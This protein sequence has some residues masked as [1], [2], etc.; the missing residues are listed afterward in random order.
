MIHEYLIA[1]LVG[2]F[3]VLLVGGVF[4]G[5]H[6]FV[7]FELVE[8]VLLDRYPKTWHKVAWFMA[9]ILALDVLPWIVGLWLMPPWGS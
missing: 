4:V 2:L 9:T 1:Y 7:W 8:D 3:A 5:L 6:A